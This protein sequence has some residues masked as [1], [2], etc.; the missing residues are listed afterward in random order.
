MNELIEHF[1]NQ[2]QMA[3][4]LGVTRAYIWQW[5]KAGKVPAR[6]AIKIEELT[7]GKFKAVDLIKGA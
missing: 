6:Q 4:K 7:D 1:G 2:N 3:K 5:V